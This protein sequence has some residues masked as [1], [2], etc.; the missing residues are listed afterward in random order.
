MRTR[1]GP[2]GRPAARPLFSTR[3]HNAVT[4]QQIA[5]ALEYT[6]GAL[7]RHFRDKA[8]RVR[9]LVVDDFL[10]FFAA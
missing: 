7:Y 6:P 1:L 3:G 8:A 5:A 10:A 4:I 9:A 2:P